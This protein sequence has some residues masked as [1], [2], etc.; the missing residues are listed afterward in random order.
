MFHSLPTTANFALFAAAAAAVWSAGTRLARHVDTIAQTTGIGREFLGM[1][2][3]GGVTSLPEIAVATTATLQG[4]PTLSIN[5]VLGSAAINLLIL[6]I[7]DAVIG[8]SALTSVVASP[9][10]LLQGV[11]GIVL[12][13]FAVGPAIAGDRI[14]FGIGGWCW[15]MLAVYVL[16]IFLLSRS[17]AD[18]R[19]KATGTGSKPRDQDDTERPL[20]GLIVRT[21]LA[22][23]AILVAGFVLAQSGE[24]LSEQTGLGTSFFGA[25]FLAFSTSLP[26]ISTVVAAVRMRQYAMAVSDVFG[27]NL[28]NVTIIVLVDAL[29][30]GGPVLV[31]AGAFA[32]FGALLALVLTALFLAGMIERRDRTV[33]R[34][35]LDSFA[36]LALYAGGVTVL[37]HLR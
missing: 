30:P 14:I 24:A 16:G 10:V 2:L 11:L 27:T 18:H 20:R 29:H 34:M 8:R 3:L 15:L 28:F 5:D 36:A 4:A 17:H 22:G 25:V 19:W 33:L 37:Y 13:A 26:E 35:G 7:A 32:A 21:A 31:E 1:V 23:A 12:M 9:G 6:A